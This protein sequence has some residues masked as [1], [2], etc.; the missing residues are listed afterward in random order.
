MILSVG[1]PHRASKLE[2]DDTDQLYTDGHGT[3]DTTLTTG[4]W[5]EGVT[6]VAA[7]ASILYVC[8]VHMH[9]YVLCCIQRKP[10]SRIC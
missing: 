10:V 3:C 2:L 1:L 7:S 8:Y 6:Q 4:V 9:V 5:E